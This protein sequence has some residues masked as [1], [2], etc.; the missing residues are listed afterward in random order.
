MDKAKEYLALAQKHHF[1]VISGVVLLTS[2]ICWWVAKSRLDKEFTDNK[3]NV[4]SK[5]ASMD[6]IKKTPDHPNDK[7]TEQLRQKVFGI[8]NNVFEAWELRFEE[9]KKVPQWQ[10]NLTKPFLDWIT[11]NP[12]DAEIKANWRE[13]YRY[14]IRD[15]ID[16][17]FKQVKARDLV[18][19]ANP[20][21]VPPA[22][23]NRPP[24]RAGFNQP[25]NQ[26]ALIGVT[27]EWQGL[28][29]WDEALREDLR[30]KYRW[31]T[32]P[33]TL[34]V[35]YA[36]E[37]LWI[38]RALLAIIATTNKDAQEHLVASIKRIESLNIGTD[39][40]LPETFYIPI[41]AAPGAVGPGGEGSEGQGQPEGMTDTV[42]GLPPLPGQVGGGQ[43]EA[44][45][46]PAAAVSQD[47]ITDAEIKNG[48]Y[49]D[50][51]GKQVGWNQAD[52]FAEFKIMPFEMHLLMDQRKIPDLLANCANSPLPVEVRQVGITST[53]APLADTGGG[54]EA[55]SRGRQP[56]RNMMMQSRGGRMPGEGAEGLGGGRMSQPRPR[57]Q[58]QNEGAG[59]GG[60][61]DLGSAVEL[62]PYDLHV[63][64]RGV[65]YIFNTPDRLK[66]GKQPPPPEPAIA[67]VEAGAGG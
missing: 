5:F 49:V 7:V 42:T 17:L 55:G 29:A 10:G 23:A 59:A 32:P 2:L 9:Q 56:P 3:T 25:G 48:R 60:A 28:V 65:I 67:P 43:G 53:E 34:Q 40:Q 35:R 31:K 21:N 63:E 44:G 13:D 30:F 6:G 4:E 33:T 64:L 15:E 47:Q 54:G 41:A 51:K 39:V 38:Y 24:V 45:A 8:G 18:E 14:F 12:P 19:I 58:R 66:V 57:P 36:N 37:D 1:W 52:P 62:R 16:K 11:K 46:E 61:T 20:T 50:A 22:A 27:H 26:Q